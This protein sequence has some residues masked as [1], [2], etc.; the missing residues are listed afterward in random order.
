MG[1]VSEEVIC[2]KCGST[3]NVD[4]RYRTGD[5]TLLCDTCGYH[6]EGDEHGIEKGG[7][8]GAYRIQY[9]RFSRVGAFR[10]RKRAQRRFRPALIADRRILAITVTE[11]VRGKWK[12]V[13]I[14]VDNKKSV[15][16][17]KQRM[18]WRNRP[19]NNFSMDMDDI[20]F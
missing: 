19:T 8:H 6:E 20:E 14:K 13:A 2:P 17:W 7:G 4:F 11:R 5:Y 16:D 1:S 10:T 12:R 3:A 9:D 18:Q 15:R